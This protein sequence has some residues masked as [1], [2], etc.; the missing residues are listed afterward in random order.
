[1]SRKETYKLGDGRAGDGVED[2][3]HELHQKHNRENGRH[4]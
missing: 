2:V 4:G 3:Q 1:V